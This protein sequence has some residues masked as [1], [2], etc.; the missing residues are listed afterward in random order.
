M[1]QNDR[2]SNRTK[3]NSHRT[4]RDLVSVNAWFI[5]DTDDEDRFTLH[6]GVSFN[7]ERLGGGS[8]SVIFRLA[9]KRC[10]IIFVPPFGEPFRVDPSSVRMPRP[11]NPKSVL[12]TRKRKT[13]TAFGGVLTLNWTKPTG[14]A[15]V[16]GSQESERETEEASSQTIGMYHELWKRVGSNHAW[17]VDGKDLDE[18][19][20]A[21]PVFDPQNEP[22]LTLI[23]RRSEVSKARDQAQ[24]IE[25]IA[26]IRVQ[27]LREDID[28]YDIRFTD[29]EQQ[30][31]FESKAHKAEKL[32][33]AREVLKDA[34]LREGLLAGDIATDP[35]A[36][37]TICDVSI[38]I[39]E[40]GS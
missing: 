24:K 25:P 29:D 7:E 14:S 33:V 19:R 31:T 3:D 39:I 9:V 28:I 12:Q 4:L 23:D 38:K 15:K 35:Y 13:R 8:S 21:G 11:L 40:D 27:C 6:A 10:E 17:S 5:Q 37:M 34:L 16:E 2:H 26:S 36:Q 20:L 30:R 18:G 22:R 32:L 1:E